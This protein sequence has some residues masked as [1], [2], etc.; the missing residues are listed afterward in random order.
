MV[1]DVA[2]ELSEDNR[3]QLLITRGFCHGFRILSE[4]SVFAYKCDNSYAPKS[5]GS[6]NYADKCRLVD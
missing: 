1:L 3:R 4:I 5:K 2:L 6:G